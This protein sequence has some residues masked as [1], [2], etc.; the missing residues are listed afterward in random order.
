VSEST[1]L[2]TAARAIYD[3]LCRWYDRVSEIYPDANVT[4]Q[5]TLDTGLALAVRV[6][7]WRDS[8][9]EP[10]LE[11]EMRLE[12][13]ALTDARH[14]HLLTQRLQE[15]IDDLAHRLPGLEEDPDLCLST[16]PS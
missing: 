14:Y 6:S 16:T 13:E 5:A 8:K 11:V 12:R 2:A 9:M 15:M 4:W 3:A 1:E 7:A 10:H